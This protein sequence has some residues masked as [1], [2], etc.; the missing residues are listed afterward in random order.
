MGIPHLKRHLEPYAQRGA[1]APCDVVVDGPAFAYHIL[2]LCQR[3][4]LRSSPFELPSYEVLG[5]TAIAWLDR[6]EEGGLSVY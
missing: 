4:T 2:N 1:I 3:K 5:R 6:I